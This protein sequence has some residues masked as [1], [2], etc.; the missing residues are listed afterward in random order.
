MVSDRNGCY[1][2]QNIVAVGGQDGS[3]PVLCVVLHHS[4]NHEGGPGLR[5]YSTRS[6]DIGRSWTPLLLIDDSPTRQSHDGYQLVHERPDGSERIFVFY[7]CNEGA[8]SHLNAD[9]T[10]GG[11][12]ELPRSDMQ[13]EDGYY[14]RFSD[15]QARSWSNIACVIPVRRTRIDR[16]NPWQGKIMGMFMCDKPSVIDGAVYFAFQKTPDGGGETPNSEVF[17]L[18]SRNLL[19]V[20]NP[21]DAIWETLPLGD[22]G[23]KPPGGELALGEEPHIVAI[24][25]HWPGRVFTLWRTETGKLA[26]AYS[27]DGGES[28]EPSFWLT[29]E[30][31]ALGQGGVRTIKNPRGAITPGRLRLRSPGGRNEFVLLF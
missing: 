9:D 13:L 2:S 11:R 17:F 23:L 28:W 31:V 8:R 4:E 7:G 12:S 21:Q 19:S 15:D 22:V 10:G 16:A 18:R 5:L 24:G 29:Y 6:T 26:A 3:A 25:A 1:D 14:F 27:S 20:A 30:G